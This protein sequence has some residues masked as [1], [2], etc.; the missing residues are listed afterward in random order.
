MGTKHNIFAYTE[1]TPPDGYPAYISINRD[2]QG[3]H[4]ITVRSRGY[5]GQSVG[6]IEVSPETL[7]VLTMAVVADLYRDEKVNS[8]N[9]TTAQTDVQIECGIPEYERLHAQI[10]GLRAE[11]SQLEVYRTAGFILINRLCNIP[12]HKNFWIDRG[13]AMYAICQYEKLIGTG[14]IPQPKEEPNCPDCKRKKAHSA[15]DCAKEG[16]CPK[17]YVKNLECV[18][19]CEVSRN[20]A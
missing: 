16:F 6:T 2:D 3:R 13:R 4:T 10:A 11:V 20:E 15:D 7:D 8:A 5:Y 18:E 9:F 14:Q 12:K 19:N 1:V 17:W